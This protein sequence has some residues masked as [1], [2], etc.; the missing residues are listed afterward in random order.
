VLTALAGLTRTLAG[1]I[2]GLA[3]EEIGYAAWFALS[4]LLA[5]PAFALLP[6]V[7]ERVGEG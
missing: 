3:V 4:L 5:L 6:W 7:R 1:A 2:S